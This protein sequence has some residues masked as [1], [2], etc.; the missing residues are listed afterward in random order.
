[1]NP[2]S[3]EALLTDTVLAKP[4][5]GMMLGLSLPEA[6]GKREEADAKQRFA[7]RPY[8]LGCWYSGM[9]ESL[10]NGHIV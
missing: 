8:P 1:M 3:R 5:K 2:D 10:D 9:V 4:A 6:T 7:K